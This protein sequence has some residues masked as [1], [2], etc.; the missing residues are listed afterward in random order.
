MT[1][2]QHLIHFYGT[3]Q[4][5][6]QLPPGITWLHPQQSG[7][8]MEIAT[9]FFKKFYGDNNPRRLLLGINP[10]R[11]GA[12]VTGVNFTAAKQ[13]TQHCGIEHDLRPQSELSAEFIY[14][15]I[16]AYGGP[17]LFYSRFFIGSVCPLGFVKDGKNINY[18]DDKN[19]LQT[20]QPFIIKNLE[21]LLLFGVERD[22]CICIGGE[23][24]FKFLDALNKQHHFFKT[25]VPLPHPRFILQYRRRDRDLH[26]QQYL[27]VLQK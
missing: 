15:V 27:D 21:K 2:A 20:V 10:G 4:P 22:T 26:L 14:D 1:W 17:S 11:F 24:N 7:E 19:L 23:K 12:G 16:N 8:V 18:Y 6:G 3:L 5:P 25:I 13:L 9:R